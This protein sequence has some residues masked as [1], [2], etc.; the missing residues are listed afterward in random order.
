MLDW[1]AALHNE[2]SDEAGHTHVT[3]TDDIYA[4]TWSYETSAQGLTPQQAAE[5]AATVFLDGGDPVSPPGTVE[6]SVYDGQT[7]LGEFI[8]AI[9]AREHEVLYEKCDGCHLFIEPN[10]EGPEF[11][12]YVHLHRGNDADETLDQSHQAAPSGRK[13]NLLTWKTYGPLAMRERFT[14]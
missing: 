4:C 10:D 2:L 14:S 6:F 13:A 9:P 1:H 12:Q 11:A 5:L 7:S 8:V 3:V